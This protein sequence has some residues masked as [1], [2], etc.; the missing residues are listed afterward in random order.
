MEAPLEVEVIVHGPTVFLQC[1]QCELVLHETGLSRGVRAD[2]LGSALPEDLERE[3]ALVRD[4]VHRLLD[5]Y[6]GRVA[7]KV[8]DATS[9]RGVWRALRHGVHRY[10]AIVVGGREKF[11]GTDLSAADA[12]IARRV[13]AIASA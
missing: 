2:Q 8:T 12:H 3:Y 10:P 9:L 5:T 6:G 1:R 11:V 13:G 7:V 4:W